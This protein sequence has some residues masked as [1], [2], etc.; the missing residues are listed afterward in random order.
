MQ[1]VSQTVL[2]KHQG[3]Q[4]HNQWLGVRSTARRQHI[5]LVTSD[6]MQ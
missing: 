1:L 6:N 3:P 4:A 2:E 5:Q